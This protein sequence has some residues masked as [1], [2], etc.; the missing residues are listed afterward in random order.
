MDV[1]LLAVETATGHQS[2]AV[3]QGDR[4]LA[5]ADHDAEGKHA[6][7]LVPTIDRLLR[8]CGL[9]LADLNGLVVSIGP[10]S[11][12]GLRVGL[13]TMMGF[14]LITGLPLAAVPTLEA[15]AWNVRPD[16][17]ARTVQGSVRVDGPPSE[18]ILC[19][20][21][22]ARTGEVYWAYY[23][24]SVGAL[25]R[26]GEERV[27]TLDAL[28]QSVEESVLVFGEGWLANREKLMRLFTN[29]KRAVDE[30]PAE[31]MAASAVSVGLVGRDYLARGQVASQGL[32]P[33]YIQ[34]P[35]AEIAIERRAA[36]TRM[37]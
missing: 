25:K 20:I 28:A 26:I 2:V 1:R 21:L 36:V 31:A 18:R 12:T 6:K 4:V 22:K 27:G 30:G 10:G 17:A 23:Q 15:M 5:Q 11:F 37:R 9:S 19:P 32:S 3:L 24:W 34:R 7:H 8:T 14:R 35:E 13:A 33:R 29:N 16:R